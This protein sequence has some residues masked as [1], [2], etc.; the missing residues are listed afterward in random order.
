[1]TIRLLL[2]LCIAALCGCAPDDILV[3]GTYTVY[4][5]TDYGTDSDTITMGRYECWIRRTEKPIWRMTI[6]TNQ[7]WNVGDHVAMVKTS[8]RTDVH[9]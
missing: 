3:D 1:M 4:N 5:V 2:L 7:Q 8:Q 6:R 9:P